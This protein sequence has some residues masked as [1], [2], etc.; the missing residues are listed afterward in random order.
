MRKRK[1]LSPME[2]YKRNCPFPIG[3]TKKKGILYNGYKNKPER[4]CY[5]TGKPYAERH[6]IFGGPNRQISIREGFQVDLCPELHRE[7]H[8]NQTDWAKRENR[9][10]REKY[11]REY[12]EKLKAAG[13]TPAEARRAWMQLI[14]RNFLEEIEDGSGGSKK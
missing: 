2:E 1:K 13:S 9:Y 5:Y 3:K 12:E 14:G 6:E 4:T 7:L 8:A 10:W 11:Q